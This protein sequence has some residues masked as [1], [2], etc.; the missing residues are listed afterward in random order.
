MAQTRTKSLTP[1]RPTAPI[2]R[3][4]ASLMTLTKFTLVSEAKNLRRPHP[5]PTSVNNRGIAPPPVRPFL[6]SQASPRD[7]DSKKLPYESHFVIY[8]SSCRSC[9]RLFLP[10]CFVRWRRPAR[11]YTPVRFLSSSPQPGDINN[12]SRAIWH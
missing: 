6:F 2:S 9:S 12:P 11:Q 8:F 7:H 4:S 1:P 5:P 10:I 3:W